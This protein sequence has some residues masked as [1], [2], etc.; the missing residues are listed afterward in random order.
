MKEHVKLGDKR[1]VERKFKVDERF[2][3]K[4]GWCAKSEGP[5]Q[6]EGLCHSLMCH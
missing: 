3:M 2:G 6:E 4:P 5:K 1:T